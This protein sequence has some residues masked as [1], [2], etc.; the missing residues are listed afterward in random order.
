MM[1]FALIMLYLISGYGIWRLGTAGIGG[2]DG[3]MEYLFDKGYSHPY[4]T[5]LI[6]ETLVV[7]FWPYFI[8]RG[9]VD[10]GKEDE[11]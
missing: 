6:A 8:V 11:E 7:I 1:I 10:M 2:K 5:V 3:Y 4:A 9:I